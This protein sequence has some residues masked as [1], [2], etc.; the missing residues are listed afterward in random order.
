MKDSAQGL[1]GAIARLVRRS[2]RPGQPPLST[3]PGCAFGAV[4]EER[5]RGLQQQ[6][7]EIKGRVNGLFYTL[8]GAVIAEIVLRIV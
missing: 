3:A 1:K 4:E 2:P 7:D 8:V 6:L 5:L